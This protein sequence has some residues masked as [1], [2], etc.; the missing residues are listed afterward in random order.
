MR[1][2]GL[3]WCDKCIAKSNLVMYLSCLLTSLEDLKNIQDYQLVMVMFI[4]FP[5]CVM[6]SHLILSHICFS[7]YTIPM[8]TVCNDVLGVRDQKD[9]LPQKDWHLFF[10]GVG[11]Y[12]LLKKLILCKENLNVHLVFETWRTENMWFC[13]FLHWLNDQKH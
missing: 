13:Y 3:S 10:L 4:T 6:I 12:L 7:L 8:N 11:I 2:N 9:T 5:F 1:I